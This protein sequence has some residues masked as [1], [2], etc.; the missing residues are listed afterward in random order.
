MR[1]TKHQRII[2]S[3]INQG[4]IYDIPSYLRSFKKGH[5]KT[6]DMDV[7]RSRFTNDESGK[8]Y[9]VLKDDHSL[10]TTSYPTQYFMG[11]EIHVPIM[12]PRAESDIADD[13]WTLCEAKFDE[14]I[15]PS[16]FTYDEQEF[17]LDFQKGAFV[18]DDFNDILNFISLWSY[19]RREGLIFEVSEP[20][21][22]DEIS[23]LYE[24]VPYSSPSCS[25]GIKIEWESYPGYRK[26]EEKEPVIKPVKDIL[27]AVPVRHAK[28]FLDKEWIMNEDHLMMCREFLGKRIYPTEASHNYAANGYRTPDEKHRNLN[29]TVA[30]IALLVSVISFF[31]GW[32]HPNNSY[33]PTL[34]NMAQQIEEIKMALDDI[35]N[36]QLST[37]E[38]DQV[39]EKIESIEE[40]LI[41]AEISKNS[42]TVNLP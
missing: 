10:F 9:K 17:I 29:S 31:Y 15:P 23:M 8:Q 21:S 36:N 24:S 37:E 18:A 38:V 35:G 4:E 40:I 28:E 39:Y 41:R 6:Y 12:L 20:V 30:V 7:I 33:Q 22:K 5:E 1:L 16:V 42:D 3:R 14:K 19:L 34:D 26:L 13:E 32:L 2:V 25:E 11:Q 27:L